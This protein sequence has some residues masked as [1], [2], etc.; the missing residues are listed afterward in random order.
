MRPVLSRVVLSVMAAAVALAGL[1]IAMRLVDGYRPLTLRL[2]RRSAFRLP[3]GPKWRQSLQA[4][5][6]VKAL[7]L[8]SGIEP[9]WYTQSPPAQE[10]GPPDNDLA[11][12]ARLYPSIDLQANYEWNRRAVLHALCEDEH[13]DQAVFNNFKDVFTF[14]P[15]DGSTV[16][17][18]RFLQHA[19]YPTGLRT[20][21]YGFRGPDIAL[22]KRDNVVRVAFVG[23]STTIAPHAEPYSY[24]ELVGYWLNLWSRQRNL[25]I[26]FE[27]INAGRE[28]TNSRSMQAVVRQE[29]VPLE[30][31]LVVDY[32]GANQFWPSEYVQAALPPRS[33]ISGPPPGRAAQFSAVARRVENMIHTVWQPG[34]EPAKPA[35]PVVW[36]PGLSEVDPDLQD[37]RLPESLRDIHKDLE[38]IRTDLASSG[39]RLV[40]TS[41]A[42]LVENGLVLDMRRDA[43]IFQYLNVTYWPFSYQ[44]VRRFVDFQNRVFRKAAAE[45]GLDF[46]DFS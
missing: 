46:I 17:T 40:M 3:D 2:V 44:H 26:T 36:P 16:P 24:P 14:E 33:P 35:L 27:A 25:P 38:T 21:N 34:S 4:G 18:F 45:R 42:W 39:G 31:D 29:L 1:E 22:N 20:N 15:T 6:Y 10:V 32:E 37:P 5:D 11:E 9:S 13:P 7:P 8:A 41:F 28:G 30:P 19:K 12:R 23:A 43:E